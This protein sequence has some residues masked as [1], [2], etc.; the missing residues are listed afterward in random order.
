M[1]YSDKIIRQHLEGNMMLLKPVKDCRQKH[2]TTDPSTCYLFRRN[3]YQA[4]PQFGLT[5]NHRA[6][7]QNNKTDIP[8][9]T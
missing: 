5:E 2:N 7:T 4:Q 9:L 3:T 6:T 1:P 8:T